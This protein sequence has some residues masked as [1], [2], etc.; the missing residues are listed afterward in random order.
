M[1]KIGDK[2]YVDDNGDAVIGVVAD[3][4]N[5]EVPYR[6]R[7]AKRAYW[8]TKDEVAPCKTRYEVGDVITHYGERKVIDALEVYEGKLVLHFS[9]GSSATDSS[10]EDIKPGDLVRV[11]R[12]VFIWWDYDKDRW[13]EVVDVD[14]YG[15]DIEVTEDTLPVIGNKAYFGN[16][17]IL[18]HKRVKRESTV[19]LPTLE[20]ETTMWVPINDTIHT[21]IEKLDRIIELLEEK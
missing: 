15:V 10:F 9:D 21:L 18:E 6:V 14:E 8:F 17:H 13:Y 12:G 16:K 1:L 3:V 5:D 20:Y 19:G 11:E 2:V 4:D 7:L